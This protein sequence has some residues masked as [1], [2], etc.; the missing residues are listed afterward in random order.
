M[1][2][3]PF[4]LA[5]RYL[6]E[7]L[8]YKIVRCFMTLLLA[9][10][11][12]HRFGQYRLFAVKALWLGET[13][14]FVVLIVAYLFRTKPVNRSQGIR[15]IIIPLAGSALPFAL[16][17]SPPSPLITGN[18][19]LFYGLLWGM[20]A[21]TFLTAWGM[22]TLR[23]AFSITVE[24]RVLITAGPYRLL[25]HPI[26]CGEIVAAAAVATIRFSLANLAISLLFITMQLYRT[27][28]EE[29][30]L[31]QTFPQYREQLANSF[32]FWKI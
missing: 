13:A 5:S 21:G 16:L 28:M 26:Y 22:W 31:M 30:K 14:L 11:L 23:R 17:A 19:L 20:T 10:F 12:L 18:S 24:A 15:E 6:P 8:L 4:G 7:E 2:F 9:G 1:I 3:D 32:W 25:R 27:R 29:R